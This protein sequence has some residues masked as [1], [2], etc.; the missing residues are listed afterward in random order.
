M[1]FDFRTPLLGAFLAGSLAA[2]AFA[3]DLYEPPVETPPA[4]EYREVSTGGWYIRGDV[5]YSKLKFRGADYTVVS[6]TTDCCGEVIGARLVD[7]NKLDGKLRNSFSFGGG[8]GYKINHYL[9]TD[10]TVDYQSKSKFRGRT[11]GCDGFC[12]S[13]DLTDMTALSLLANAY[14][15]LG[16]WHGLT[17]YIGGG[18]GG[19]HVKWNTLRNTACYSDGACD[20]TLSHE[21]HDDWRFAYS[22]AAGV[23]YAFTHNLALDVGYRYTRVTGGRMFGGDDAEGGPY[24]GHGR[25]NGI[26]FHSV[27]AGLRY[28]FGSTAKAEPAFYEPLPVYK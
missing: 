21:G 16:T 14:V 18:L 19:A 12:T 23:S 28:S 22:A 2:P 27:K 26:D 1:M 9:R 11:E 17:P 4:I 5:D 20:A 8:I 3:A 25:D 10:F 13:T 6:T 15:D 7:G 24:T